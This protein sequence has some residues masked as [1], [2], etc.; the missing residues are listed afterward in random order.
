MSHFVRPTG[1]ATTI[2]DVLGRLTAIVVAARRH[3]SRI[4]YFAAVYLRITEAVKH[5]IAQGA[6]KDA[7]WVEQLDVEF[8]N[9]YFAALD[10]YESGAKPN[11]DPQR[12]WTSAFAAT[13]LW[14]P[15]ILQHVL[16]G[17]NAHINFDLGIATAHAAGDDL[18]AHYED[19]AQVNDFAASEVAQLQ[20]RLSRVSPLLGAFDLVNGSREDRT[21]VNFGIDRAREQAWEVAELLTYLPQHRRDAELQVIDRN[22]ANLARLIL[23]P[24]GVLS[25][26]ALR[27]VRAA[28]VL[29]VAA[30]IRR[31]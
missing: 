8:A 5:G 14:R 27:S 29:P 24:P 9:R 28:E 3:K 6:F 26:L 13:S 12:S 19:F 18:E 23:D 10:W 25:K 31:L 11:G 30:V 2:D 17:I 22:T 21:L 20:L 1:P 16:L 7:V 4:G 15:I